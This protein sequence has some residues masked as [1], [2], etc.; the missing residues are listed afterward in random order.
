MLLR[1]SMAACCGLAVGCL[2]VGVSSASANLRDLPFDVVPTLEIPRSIA[3]MTT[4]VRVVVEHGPHGVV[5][6]HT[7]F[8]LSVKLDP[9]LAR[10]IYTIL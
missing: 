10:N 1:A 4:A 9:V 6:N 8:E 3:Y 7:T 2:S 5:P